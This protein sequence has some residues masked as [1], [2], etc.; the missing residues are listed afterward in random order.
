MG[1]PQ[2]GREPD[3][4][5][6]QTVPVRSIAPAIDDERQRREARRV[7][8]AERLFES[9][10]RLEIKIRKDLSYAK[11]L[12][13]FRLWGFSKKEENR[14]RLQS[15]LSRFDQLRQQ[16]TTSGNAAKP[17]GSKQPQGC[18]YQSPCDEVFFAIALLN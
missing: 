13:L 17:A 10:P 12:G 7:K 16:L 11:A 4:F 2:E 8:T 14:T 18:F 15:K 6:K 3:T 9:I 1:L 5:A